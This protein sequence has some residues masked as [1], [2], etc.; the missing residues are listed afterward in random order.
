VKVALIGVG[1]MGKPMAA[2]LVKGGHE[3]FLFDADPSR[4]AAAAG[5]IGAAPLANL[6]AAA[7]AEIFVTMLPDG[8]VVRAVALGDGGIA[9]FAKP[10]TIVID[11]SS[12]QPLVTR[13][14]GA[15]LAQKGIA[16]IDAPVSGGVAKAVTGT[17]TIMIGSDDPSALARAKPVLSCLGS[18]FFEVGG[19]G[20]GHAAKALNNVVAAANYAVLA[21]ALL[22]AER[23]G[24]EPGMFVDIVSA[25]TGQSF[26]SSVVM[27]NFV[28]TKKFNTGF[29][30]GLLAKDAAIAA[31]LCK[32]LGSDAPHIE[33]A[34][35]RWAQARDILGA[36]EDN[37]RA[38]LA[39][40]G[41][42]SE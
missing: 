21:E 9:S 8:H 4:A 5:E 29:S 7:V 10:G 6:R 20:A 16:L 39:W 13:D 35:Q 33:L 1:N 30:V 36:G 17:L 19:L 32:E 27:K 3:V 25:S 11:M 2:N 38:I 18:T 37:S 24:I 23:Y 22:T 15:A 26:L 28:L 34:S 31:E 42:A 12:S 40:R 14:T 41:G